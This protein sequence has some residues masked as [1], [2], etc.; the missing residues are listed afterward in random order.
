MASKGTSKSKGKALSPKKRRDLCAAVDKEILRDVQ[1]TVG[2]E[3]RLARRMSR[4]ADRTSKQRRE[5]L[6]RAAKVLGVSLS[7]IEREH[8]KAAVL[9]DRWLDEE[10]KHAQAMAKRRESTHRRQLVAL[11]HAAALYTK[12][13]NP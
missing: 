7:D 4:I 12:Q 1:D 13:R 5:L 6:E 10:A 2:R 3:V 11:R 8:E 9:L